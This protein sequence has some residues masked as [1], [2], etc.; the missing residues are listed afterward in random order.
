MKW[1]RA[2]DGLEEE[3]REHI[4]RETRENMERGMGPEEARTAALRKFGN[5]ARV[6]EDTRDVWRW[7]WIEQLLQD[8]RYGLRF[9]RRSPRFTA[10]VVLTLALGI[11][12]N[13]AVFSV[14]NTVLLK[15]LACPNP[16]RLVWLGEYDPNIQRDWVWMPD[17]FE[18][19]RRAQSYAGMAAYG[20]HQAAIETGQGAMQV[21]GV[22]VAG[23]FWNVT[24]ARAALGRLFA[25]EDTDAIVLSWDLFDREFGA[26]TRIVGK[27]VAMN[28]RSAT[29]T[30]VL[31]KSFRFQ[32]PVWW[33]ASRPEP[34]EVY[35]SLP[36]RGQMI[37]QTTQVVA[38]LKRGVRIAQAQAELD[39]LEKHLREDG[40]Q[41]PRT[42]RVRISPL[43][44]KLTGSSRWALMVLF[45][46]G[47]FLLLI[48]CV[49]VANLLL[50]RATLR[51]KEIAIRAA[52]G[53]GRARVVRQL[54]VESVLLSLAGG[55]AGL[56]LARWTIAALVRISPY[57]IPRLSET[58]MDVR[59]LAFTLAVSALTGM[60]FGAGPAISLWR[61][62]LQDAL[63]EGTRSSAG[64][65]GLR[66]R[67]ALVAAELSLAIVLLTGAGLMLKSFWRMNQHSP[68]FAPEKVIVMKVRFTGL[69][70]IPKL[71][72]QAYFRE[73][74]R[75]IEGAPGVQS[76]G[77]STWFLFA[78]TPAFPADIDQS[79]PR[80]IR[81]NAVTSGYLEALG[82][83]LVKG[84]WI[85]DSESAVAL[86]NESMA[87]R[88]FGSVDPIGR[89]YSIPRPVTIVGILADLKYSKLDAEA[90]PEIFVP[91]DTETPNLYGAEIAVRT[92]A[93]PET[94]APALRKLI[95]DIDPSQP[96]FDVK[97]LDQALAESIA[98]R[99]FN[100]FL[101]VSFASSA[102]LLALVGIYGVIAYS[103]AARTREIGVRMALGA[104]RGQVARMVVREALPIAAAGIVAGLAAA[105]GLTRL[106]A[107]LLY[108]VKA[109]DPGTFAAVAIALGITAVAAC[110]GPA[111]K[112]A[113]VD[114]TVA[115]R[116]E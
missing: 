79:Q 5:V 41:W 96:V 3:L 35:V 33:T 61:T 114:P 104:R 83:R 28:S 44:E 91:H 48:A 22:Y 90:I 32:F 52:V 6:M 78:R 66:M 106:M 21:T 93:N 46:A 58:S 98:P 29:I 102:L 105:L 18:W 37:A 30:G 108:G 76:A 97:T 20:Y 73:V 100:L 64:I 40:G 55:T 84:R 49:N 85:S 42:A 11:G 63:K 68:G 70:Y 103:V 38:A 87:R 4:E 43:Q 39:S 54:L 7:L 53:A 110:V 82:M 12:M 95:S 99:R 109:T 50:A 36:P 27:P 47:A 16:E 31:P 51:R 86:M 72:Q 45:A 24:G 9:L 65:S 15:P 34:V 1:R 112:A 62:D 115:L 67:R 19:R 81:V 17:F 8:F 113:A 25:A 23:D 26:D 89:Q 92:D 111:L 71:A 56:L 77:L 116:S 101:L 13:T 2:L 59:V 74:L 10:V 88:A 60:L 80:V 57:A 14:V 75:R 69:R 94:L 107:A